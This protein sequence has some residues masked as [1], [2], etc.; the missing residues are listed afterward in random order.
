ML[1][2]NKRL[3]GTRSALQRLSGQFAG[4][5]I[6]PLKEPKKLIKAQIRELRELRGQSQKLVKDGLRVRNIDDFSLVA[7]EFGNAIIH[8]TNQSLSLTKDAQAGY[9]QWLS[10][11]VVSIGE[12]IKPKA[13]RTPETDFIF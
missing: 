3:D 4:L 2:E 5:G 6:S 12:A 1:S 8:Y 10:S 7:N 9:L 13:K 11:S